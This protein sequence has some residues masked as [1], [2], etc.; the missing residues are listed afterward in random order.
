M[1]QN[2]LFDQL[3]STENFASRQRIAIEYLQ[4]WASILE[5]DAS[6]DTQAAY[7]IAGLMATEFAQQLPPES[8]I[9]E[10]LIIAGELEVNPEDSEKLHQELIMKIRS[11]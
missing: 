6:Q 5:Q 7:S 1:E 9:D 4:E 10:I 11:L 8:P 3:N 2:K